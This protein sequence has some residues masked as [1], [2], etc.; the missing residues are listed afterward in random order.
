MHGDGNF[1]KTIRHDDQG[2]PFEREFH[3]NGRNHLENILKQDPINGQTNEF[4]SYDGN[5]N[6]K[7]N[8]ING[9]TF[10]YSAYNNLPIHS[11]AYGSDQEY[12]YDEE[13]KR[14]KKSINNGSLVDY[15]IGGLIV[16]GNGEPKRIDFA[17][18]FY[19]FDEQRKVYEIKDWLGTT[20]SAVS[21]NGTPS[22]VRD[23]YPYG[24]LLNGRSF[25]T[26]TE[27][28]RKQFTGH[29]YDSEIG[30]D[31]HGARYYDRESGRYL[32]TDPKLYDYKHVTPYNYVEGNPISF[33]DPDGK[34]PVFSSN[35]TYRREYVRRLSR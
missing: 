16:D 29:E 26:G 31:Y 22:S 32:S 20:R 5:G 3:Y 9:L 34:N 28:S 15:Y 24:K 35:G 11:N 6:L 1:E 23:H 13:G 18:G 12:R 33:V 2:L 27:D 14:S 10:E 19:L 4:Y 7:S 8:S 30:L 17:G 25:T 21:D